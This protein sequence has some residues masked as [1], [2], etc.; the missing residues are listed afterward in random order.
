[1]AIQSAVGYS[2]NIDEAYEA[3]LEI[4]DMVLEKIELQANSVGILFCH[5][6]FDFGELLRG[7]NEKL[8][9]PLIGCTTSG[10]ANDQ[11]FFEESASLM[12]L[13]A[14]DVEFGLGLGQNLKKNPEK[15]VQSACA[16]AKAMLDGNS[17]RLA[18]TFPDHGDESLSVYPE[19]ILGFFEHEL[20]KDVPVV[21]GLA[22]DNFQLKKSYQF[23]N[24]RES[25]KQGIADTTLL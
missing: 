8:D 23:L 7:I 4:G 14:D 22:G 11:G 1:M 2:E 12:L 9:I 16:S 6:D 13:T 3:G 21:G 10:E 19:K 20:G 24:K 5:I 25:R 15:A 17:P 18:M